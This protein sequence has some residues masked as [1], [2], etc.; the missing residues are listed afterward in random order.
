MVE[1][2]KI[3]R[4]RVYR[5]LKNILRSTRTGNVDH[6]IDINSPKSGFSTQQQRVQVCVYI[7][8]HPVNKGEIAFSLTI[9][10]LLPR[11]AI[12]HEKDGARQNQR[13]LGQIATVP[14][15]L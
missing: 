1:I 14:S 8:G 3:C 15:L 5:R 11:T 2:L 13:Q 7:N 6:S 9:P 12:A 10:Y 4:R